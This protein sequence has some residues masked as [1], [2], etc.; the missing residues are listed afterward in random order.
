MATWGMIDTKQMLIQNPKA[1]KNRPGI[2]ALEE[3]VVSVPAFIE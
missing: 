3:E 1:I 2:I